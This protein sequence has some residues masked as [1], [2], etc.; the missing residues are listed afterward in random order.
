M[1]FALF[2]FQRMTLDCSHRTTTD[3]QAVMNGDANQLHKNRLF[4]CS[5]FIGSVVH[6]FVGIDNN[7]STQSVL[8]AVCLLQSCQ[9]LCQFLNSFCRHEMMPTLLSGI[10]THLLQL[11][12]LPPTFRLIFCLCTCKSS[13][14]SLFCVSLEQ[15]FP[16]DSRPPF[17]QR[18][19]FPCSAHI[20]NH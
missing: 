17:S 1:R 6:V 16:P 7:R 19:Y 10:W 18:N 14:C 8:A 15:F 5:C 2:E 4:T 9:L 13:H 3:I 20:L 11:I 12:L